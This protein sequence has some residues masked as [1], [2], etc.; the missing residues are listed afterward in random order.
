MGIKQRLEEDIFGEHRARGASSYIATVMNAYYDPSTDGN[1]NVLLDIAQVDEEGNFNALKTAV[2][3]LKYGGVAQSVPPI[4]SLA[5]IMS[6][7]G[8]PENPVCLGYIESGITNEYITDDKTP[9]AP[10]Q[11]LIK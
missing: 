9:K 4:G 11:V 2:P 10:P 1:A 5:L 3:V 6:I 7:G 8:N